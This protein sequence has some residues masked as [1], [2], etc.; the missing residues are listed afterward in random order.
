MPKE[1]N[2]TKKMLELLNFLDVGTGF[3]FLDKP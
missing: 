3:K 1:E 2:I